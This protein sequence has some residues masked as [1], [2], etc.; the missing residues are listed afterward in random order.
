LPAPS[1]DSAAF[2]AS[3]ATSLATC[4]TSE[5]MSR[6]PLTIPAFSAVEASCDR[7][8]PEPDVASF[9][10]IWGIAFCVIEVS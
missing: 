4:L 5:V 9:D 10:P 7:A 6:A 8:K 1:F 3:L 2:L